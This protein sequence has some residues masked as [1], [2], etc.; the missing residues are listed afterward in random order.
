MRQMLE[1]PDSEYIARIPSRTGERVEFVDVSDVA[2]FYAKD[3]L[4]FAV[5]G[6]KHHA[7]DPSIADLEQRLPPRQWM[8][9]HRSTLVRIAAIKALHPWFG[10]KLMIR[11]KDGTELPV[12]RERA[13]QVR[14]ALGL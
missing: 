6:D 4:T 7:I 5:T 1:R 11:L 12:A 9:V 10:G 3:K 8:R 2:Y 14:T 13:S